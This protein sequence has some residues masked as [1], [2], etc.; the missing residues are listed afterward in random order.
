[1]KANELRLGNLIKFK[2]FIQPESIVTV[3]ARFFSSLAGG[4]STDQIKN[5]E[6]I[7]NYYSGIPLTPEILVKAGLS[8]GTG[9]YWKTWGTNGVFIVRFDMIYEKFFIEAGKGFSLVCEH[10]HTLQNAFYLF[11]L[12]HELDIQ[13]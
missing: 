5:D 3:N 2:N 12:G 6:E 13:L 1:M 4:R 8:F 10:L 11:S 7:N 9:F